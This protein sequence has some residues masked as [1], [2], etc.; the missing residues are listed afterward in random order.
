MRHQ[1]PLDGWPEAG[2]I[3]LTFKLPADAP[4]SFIWQ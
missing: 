3:C 1:K 4:V 2:W